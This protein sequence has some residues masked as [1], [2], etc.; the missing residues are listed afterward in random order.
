MGLPSISYSLIPGASTTTSVVLPDPW[1]LPGQ[2]IGTT[3][4]ARLANS[5]L[6]GRNTVCSWVRSV[7]PGSS[8][9]PGDVSGQKGRGGRLWPFCCSLFSSPG[10]G[11]TVAE[12]MWKSRPVVASRL[13]GIQDQIEHGVN[14]V[15]LE[16]PHDLAAFG[17]AVTA[18]LD[19]PATAATIGRA[20]AQ[21]VRER[22]LAPHSLLT[23]LDLLN[24]L[25]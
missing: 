4:D 16:D 3:P 14:G 15:L 1:T 18:L 6:W 5:E 11:L 7:S 19:S 8:C 21:R 20:A 22:F 12:A 10:F 25:L 23:Y 24:R 2:P 13:G 17:A 9:F